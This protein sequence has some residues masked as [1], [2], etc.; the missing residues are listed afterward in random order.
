MINPSHVPT[1]KFLL[2][3]YLQLKIKT[4][5]QI[6]KCNTYTLHTRHYQYIIRQLEFKKY[7]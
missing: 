7:T 6:Q 1:N 2:A 5:F 3:I 4:F